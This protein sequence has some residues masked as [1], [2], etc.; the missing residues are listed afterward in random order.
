MSRGCGAI[1]IAPADSIKLVPVCKKAIDKG[2]V[3]INIDNP[4]HRKTLKKLNLSIPF[5]GSDNRQ[6]AAMVGEYIKNR[7]NGH[8]HV[9]VIEGIRG[10]E[11]ADQRKNATEN[12]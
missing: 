6:G 9:L 10:V 11:N 12:I 7:L 5:V 3:V 2:I 4:F 8:G 1:V